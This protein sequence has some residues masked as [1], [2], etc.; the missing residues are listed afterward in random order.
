MELEKRLRLERPFQEERRGEKPSL[1][2]RSKSAVRKGLSN[3]IGPVVLPRQPTARFRQDSL[4]FGHII[5]TGDTASTWPVLAHLSRAPKKSK[6]ELRP[7][8]VRASAIGQRWM[9]S[10]R[11]L[12]WARATGEGDSTRCRVHCPSNLL[13]LQI[14][15]LPSPNLVHQDIDANLVKEIA[16]FGRAVVMIPDLTDA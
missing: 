13:D 14:Q 15:G 4:H 7:G 1:S 12:A 8:V 11:R 3:A 5:A 10:L 6:P 9:T 16:C 2:T